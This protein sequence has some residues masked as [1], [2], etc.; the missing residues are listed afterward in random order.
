MRWRDDRL[1]A[2]APPASAIR[3]TLA[4]AEVTSGSGGQL[5]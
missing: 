1:V 5:A 3:E 4:P 2:G